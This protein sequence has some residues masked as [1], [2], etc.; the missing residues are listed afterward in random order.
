MLR[1]LKI[2]TQFFQKSGFWNDSIFKCLPKVCL[3]INDKKM[4]CSQCFPGEMINDSAK[5]NKQK[6]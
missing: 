4:E 6:N 1:R 2:T 3:Q 5:I